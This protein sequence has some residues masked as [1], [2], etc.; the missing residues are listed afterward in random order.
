MHETDRLNPPSLPPKT[1]GAVAHEANAGVASPRSIQA[2]R[3]A[4]PTRLHQV[5]GARLEGVGDLDLFPR[6]RRLACTELDL[7]TPEALRSA[8]RWCIR[9]EPVSDARGE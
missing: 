5:V 7:V 9:L 1:L 2:R 4:N 8:G 3:Q 6:K